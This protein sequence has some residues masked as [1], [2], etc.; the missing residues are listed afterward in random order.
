MEEDNGYDIIS[1][2]AEALGN[3]GWAYITVEIDYDIPNCTTYCYLGDKIR[4]LDFVDDDD[5][6]FVYSRTNILGGILKLPENDIKQLFCEVLEEDESYYDDVDSPVI[7]IA[8]ALDDY[9]E[10]GTN[11]KGMLKACN[12]PYATALFKEIAE[13]AKKC[14]YK[15]HKFI[16]NIEWEEKGIAHFTDK[17]KHVLHNDFR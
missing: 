16:P 3:D 8:D 12:G 4:I 1:E 17:E 10:Y 5:P 2:L 14:S 9:S 11:V 7:E 6:A 15:E 13:T